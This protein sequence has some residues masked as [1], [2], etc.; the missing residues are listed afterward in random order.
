MFYSYNKLFIPKVCKIV[1]LQRYSVLDYMSIHINLQ[2]YSCGPM[3]L[4]GGTEQNRITAGVWSV[5]CECARMFWVVHTAA[6]ASD[7]A[8]WQTLC[9][10]DIFVL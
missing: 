1:Y 9:A 7:S 10:L 6:H 2:Y 5:R 4:T 3:H 8:N